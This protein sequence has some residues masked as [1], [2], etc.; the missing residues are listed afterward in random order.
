M[1]K[2]LLGGLRQFG[3]T[4]CPEPVMGGRSTR[5]LDIFACWPKPDITTQSA[6]VR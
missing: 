4:P 5:W 1:I 3:G 2:L 6:H